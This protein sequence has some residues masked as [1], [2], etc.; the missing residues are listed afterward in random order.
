MTTHLSARLAWHDNG[1]DGCVCQQPHLNASC[2][3]QQNIRD[4]RNDEQ[5]RQSA[6]IH[7]S[8]LNGW[9]PPC[10]RDTGAYSPRGYTFVHS[11]PVER[12]F[13]HPVTEQ[14]PPY[15]CM[16]APYRWMR[17]ETFRD[18][19]EAQGLKIRGP[20]NVKKD[21]GWVYEPDRQRQ[22]LDNFWS[23]VKEGEGKALVFYYVNHGNPVDENA[24]RLIVGVGR[25]AA[26]GP[27]LYFGGTD[28][29]DPNG[30]QFPIWTRTVTQNYP[31]EG[32]RLPYQEYV[33]AGHDPK[34]IAC[35]L[36]RSALLPFS[37]I[38]EHVTDDMAVAILE[39]L[40]QSVETVRQDAKVPGPW[41]SHLHWLNDCLA[42]V[43]TGRGPFPGIGSVLQ[44]LGCKRGTAFHRIELADFVRRN[45]DP[46]AYV[47]SIL[48]G[49]SDPPAKYANDFSDARARWRAL[50]RTPERLELLNMLVR[51]ELTTD[52]VRRMADHDDRKRAG[53]VA[54]DAELVTNPY[55]ACEFDLG[56]ASSEPIDLEAIDHGMLPEGNAALFVPTDAIVVH[57]DSRRVR[58]VAVD[59]LRSAKDDGDTVLTVHDLLTRIRSRFPERRACKPD[60]S[61]VEAEADFYRTH[62]WFDFASDPQLVALNRLRELEKLVGDTVR[63]RARRTNPP[64]S[65]PIDWRAALVRR[66][67]EPT[68]EREAA[69]LTEKAAAL[70]TLFDQR[71]SV[72]TGSA[73]T[74][75]TSALKVFLEQLES[76]EGKKSVYLLAPTGK[77]RVRLST[78]TKRNAFTIHQF[79]FKENW[80]MPEIYVLKQEGGDRRSAPTV[81]IDECS[82]VS[83]DLLGTLFK[84]IDLG[85]V[86]RLI[87]VGDP[88][89]L[90]PIGPG[91]P[92]VDIV[93]WLQ[94]NHPQCVATLRTT[95]RTADDAEIGLGQSI[96]L[97]FADGYRSDTVNPADDEI[98]SLVARGRSSGDLEVHFWQNVDELNELLQLRMQGLL[99]IGLSGDYASFL[100]SL[101]VTKDP[102]KQGNWKDAERWQILSPLRTRPFGTEELNRTIQYA[103]KGGLIKKAQNQWSKSPKPF[104]EQLIVWTDKVIQTT[105]RRKRGWPFSDDAL[106]YVANGEIG[107]VTKTGTTDE[108]DHLRVG[109]STQS[110]VTYRYLR[111][112]IDEN[113]ELA[114]G[115]TVHKAQGSDFEIVFLIIPAEAK[116]LS[117]ELI[118][119]GL[120]RFRKRLVLLVE[121]DTAVLDALRRPEQ[122]A[123]HLRN[124]FLFNLSLRPDQEL[125]IPYP[126]ALIHRTERGIPVRS[127]SE[128]IVANVLDR[129]GISWEYERRLSHPD[130][131]RDYRLP[132][133]TIGFEGDIYYWE[134]L[135]MLSVPSYRDAWERKRRWYEERMGYRVV[136]P[137]GNP[138]PDASQLRPPLVITSRDG[139]DG[140]I[141]AQEIRR[142]ARK[143]ILLEE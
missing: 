132:D 141:D 134:H 22:L 43:W 71:I 58:A 120:T 105:N 33:R 53:L 113:L 30:F 92:F 138:V 11:D 84:A 77:A 125:G 21:K 104:G 12:G 59:V 110:G 85:L 101:G 90:P 76:I 127:K 128:V 102:E 29:R 66:F 109:F 19:C 42:E 100:R 143:Y 8:S 103:Y 23:K 24:V 73:G 35:Y 93:A 135:G 56:T 106:N 130:D 1:W 116:T 65:S 54:T 74:G 17:E 133:F 27:Q 6:G 117:R 28:P 119:T 36:P 25:I 115:L 88:N 94:E 95:M 16:P 4:D 7:L 50:S 55:L 37:F 107:I 89:Q 32:F 15:S 49:R 98:L 61:V 118:Y 137:G 41:P 64:P 78:E 18:V 5:E 121:K 72:L 111:G 10:S 87:L 126:E 108:G 139:E 20:E 13:L 44:Y 14:V 79:L 83:T 122:S 40:I 68:T 60:R 82:M 112:E 51:F 62:L 114:Y 142:M 123:T 31:N 80:Y 91:R 47:R 86:Q 46:W 63:G 34:A 131:V 52:Q 9:L 97:A 96:G 124:T 38:G 140:S 75:K 69:A 136:G 2:I 39:R 129:L 70:K 99:D 67:G 26:V 57:D 81:I 45:Q 3:V 48:E